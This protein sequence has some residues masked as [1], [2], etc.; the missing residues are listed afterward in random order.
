VGQCH[1]DCNGRRSGGGRRV[2][3]AA[4]AVVAAVAMAGAAGATT[5]AHHHHGGGST[6]TSAATP[7]AARIAIRYAEHQIGK[8]Y[9]FG[10]TG[11]DAF[12]CSGLV[13]MAYQAAHVPI[14]RVSWD[15][16]NALP[17]VSAAERDAG[18]LE[19]IVGSDG[20][21]RRPGHVVL[22]IS[23]NEAVEAYGTGFPIRII[24]LRKPPPGD[25]NVVG[26]A[27]PVRN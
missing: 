13:M 24:S 19:F 17:H 14:P 21:W 20:T 10:G 1:C 2:V 3:V 15:Q 5:H 8:P 12:D 26:F 16:W 11:P 22:L 23:R 4:G 9:L 25:Q 18:D 6:L 27:D 7:Q